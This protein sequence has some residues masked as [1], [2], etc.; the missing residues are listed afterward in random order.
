VWHRPLRLFKQYFICTFLRTQVNIYIMCVDF[1]W[2][3]LHV[4]AVHFCHHHVVP[5]WSL[6]TLNRDA[7]LLI[8]CGLKV[9]VNI[10]TT[11]KR[12]TTLYTKKFF[13]PVITAHC[14]KFLLQYYQKKHVPECTCPWHP[15]IHQE[16]RKIVIQLT[17]N[18]HGWWFSK[19]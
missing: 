17:L 1:Y 6:E 11:C 15:F 5:Y 7:R 12:Y 10:Y 16:S 3:L 8:N 9:I 14:I 2:I 13:S 4:S 18:S 19:H